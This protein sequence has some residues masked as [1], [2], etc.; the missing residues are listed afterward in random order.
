VIEGAEFIIKKALFVPLLLWLKH[1]NGSIKAN[2]ARGFK[3]KYLGGIVFY[4]R[5]NLFD[6]LSVNRLGA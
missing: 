2:S 4:K 6:V 5:C 3:E 1:F